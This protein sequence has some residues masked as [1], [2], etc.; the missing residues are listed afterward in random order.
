MTDYRHRIAHEAAVEMV[1]K[2]LLGAR[3][4][5]LAKL[6]GLSATQVSRICKGAFRPR[7]RAEAAAEYDRFQ[8]VAS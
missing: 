4:A 3:F 2:H 7:V 6:Y 8:K 5:D 1:V